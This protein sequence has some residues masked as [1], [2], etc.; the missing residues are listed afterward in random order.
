MSIEDWWNDTDRIRLERENSPSA[1][2]ST[3][4]LTRNA[5]LCP[6]LGSDSPDNTL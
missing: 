2:W 6:V 4:H 5:I 1:T 3:V